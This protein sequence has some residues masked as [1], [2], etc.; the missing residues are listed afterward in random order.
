MVFSLFGFF[1]SSARLCVFRLIVWVFLII[2]FLLFPSSDIIVPSYLYCLHAFIIFPFICMSHL[3]PCTWFR[4]NV[5][6]GFYFL[7][8]SYSHVVYIVHSEL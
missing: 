6:P 7:Q 2:I 5:F 3:Q 1:Y 8:V 4:Q